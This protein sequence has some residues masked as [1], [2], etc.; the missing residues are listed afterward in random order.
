[1]HT[2]I[3]TIASWEERYIYII[4]L[5]IHFPSVLVH[6]VI[7]VVRYIQEGRATVFFSRKKKI[8]VIS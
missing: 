7:R 8:E 5:L 2:P 1:M 6:F 3:W 4:A